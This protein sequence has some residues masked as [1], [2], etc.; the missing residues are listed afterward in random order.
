MLGTNGY[1]LGCLLALC[2][3]ACSGGS[4]AAPARLGDST[5]KQLLLKGHAVFGHEVRTIRPCGTDEAVWAIDST[6]LMWEVHRELAPHVEPYEE[7]FVVVQGRSGGAPTDGFGADYPGSFVID[8]VLYAAAEGFDCGLDLDSLHYRGS[9]NEPFWTLLVLG[10][11]IELIRMGEASKTWS[12][13]RSVSTES[14]I[15]YIGEANGANPVEVT[16]SEGP[17]RDSMSGAFFEY[18]ASVAVSGETL[19]GC[20]LRGEAAQMEVLRFNLTVS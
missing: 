18:R 10:S 9:G 20:A 14:D 7:I 8:R 12:D 6:G 16:V 3:F 15:R 1:I 4:G 5:G 2:A 17:C 11:A 19:E 13:V